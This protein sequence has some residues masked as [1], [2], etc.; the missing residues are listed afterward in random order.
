MNKT[1]SHNRMIYKLL[2]VFPI[3]LSFY[4]KVSAI[5]ALAFTILGFYGFILCKNSINERNDSD[6]VT[7]LLGVFGL[8]M[9]YLG[10]ARLLAI[11]LLIIHQALVIH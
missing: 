8:F 5:T 6:F 4:L 1:Q 7:A 10:V 11:C 2:F 9:F 3:L